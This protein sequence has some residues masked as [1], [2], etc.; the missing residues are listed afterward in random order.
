MSAR[1]CVFLFASATWL[2]PC[3]AMSPRGHLPPFAQVCVC[4]H[5]C[6]H[7]LG[8]L[9]V[10][11]PYLQKGTCPLVQGCGLVCVSCVCVHMCVCVCDCEIAAVGVFFVRYLFPRGNLP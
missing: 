2:P 7:L 4:L 5:V 1:V 10:L 6:V 8:V 9:C 11:P 3:A